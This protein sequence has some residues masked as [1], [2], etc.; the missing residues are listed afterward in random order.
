MR[1]HRSPQGCSRPLFWV[2]CWLLVP[3][4]GSDAARPSSLARQ[5]GFVGSV[6]DG[7]V[8]QDRPWTKAVL[9]PGR[10]SGDAWP[11]CCVLAAGGPWT[12]LAGAAWPSPEARPVDEGSSPINET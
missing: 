10:V 6:G 1:A 5:E 8:A 4:E 9:L 7:G 2:L 12:R 3:S 11:S